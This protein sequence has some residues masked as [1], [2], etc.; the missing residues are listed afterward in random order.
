M[1]RHFQDSTSIVNYDAVELDA[2]FYI[3]SVWSRGT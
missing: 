3:E 2:G 1:T